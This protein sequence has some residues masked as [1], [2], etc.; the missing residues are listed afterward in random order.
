MRDPLGGFTIEEYVNITGHVIFEVRN[1][2]AAI[3]GYSELA[4]E[5]MD[6]SHPAFSHLTKVHQISE[7]AFATV[8]EFDREM[9]GRRNEDGEAA[10]EGL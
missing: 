7:R 10:K 9:Y 8:K 3:L 1:C 4:N 5:E 6:P 2:L